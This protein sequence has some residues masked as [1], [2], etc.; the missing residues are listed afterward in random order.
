MWTRKAAASARPGGVD[1]ND[2]GKY[3]NTWH[4]HNVFL[5]VGV[6]MGWI[7]M[8]ALILIAFRVLAR[9]TTHSAST[10]AAAQQNPSSSS[11]TLRNSFSSNSLAPYNVMTAAWR[12]AGLPWGR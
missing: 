10:A 1:L 8:G 3:F 9:R 5:H 11:H 7:A 6:E 12:W 4:I 2:G